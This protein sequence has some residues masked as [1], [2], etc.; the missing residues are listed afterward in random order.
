[1]HALNHTKDGLYSIYCLLPDAW[2]SHHPRELKKLWPLW[3][4]F[5]VPGAPDLT[6]S[7]ERQWASLFSE[8]PL[9]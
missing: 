8:G 3:P 6:C 7:P 1:M 2:I 5:L 9:I 4:G